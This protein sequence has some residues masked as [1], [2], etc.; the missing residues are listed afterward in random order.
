[1]HHAYLDKFATRDSPVHRRDP[2]A[3]TAAFLALLAAAILVPPG[4]WWPFA[5]VAVIVVALWAVSSVPV[6]YLLKR[7]VVL[8]PFIIFSLV[9]FPVLYDGR[10]VWTA[11]LGPWRMSVTRE[12][13]EL[14]GNVAAKFVLGVL[15]LGLLFSVT[16]FQ[17]FLY[18]LSRLRVPQ[19]LVMQL[20]FLYRYLFVVLDEAER[21][22]RAREARSAGLGGPRLWRSAAG[23]VGTLFL[24]SY[25][26]SQRVYWAMLARGFNGEVHVL[27]R[28]R[29]QAADTLFVS[30]FMAVAAAV[31]VCWAAAGL[32]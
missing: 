26:R 17:H 15:I 12:G 23:L 31:T 6:V 1:M 7:V 28:L 9:L 2:R 8:S 4:T 5:S 3:K 22:L 32:R 25:H 19:L 18:A 21:M 24:R 11:R 29:W 27:G 13:L 16:R 14:A 30:C 10:A 20:G